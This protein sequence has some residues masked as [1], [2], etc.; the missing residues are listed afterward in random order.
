MRSVWIGLA[1]GVVLSTVVEA[2]LQ[3]PKA[4]VSR[5][6]TPQNERFQFVAATDGAEGM[7]FNPAT[8]ASSRGINVHYNTL[9]DRGKFLEHDFFL[10]NFLFN[11]GY[12]RA[13]DNSLDYHLNEYTVSLGGGIPEVTFGGSVNWLRGNL[14]NGSNGTRYTLGLLVKPHPRFSS[15]VVKS[16]INQPVIGGYKVVGKN[17]I[18]VGVYPLT[19][20]ERLT[21]AADASL[22]N[23]GNV[24]DDLEYRFLAD[25]LVVEGL[26]LYGVYG[27]IPQIDSKQFSI[28]VHVYTP[29]IDFSYDAQFDRDRDYNNGVAGVTFSTERKKSVFNP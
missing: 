1:S 29:N 20:I 14:P 2:Q 24:S 27:K 11:F 21:L 26:R 23:G 15:S 6:V 28:G 25:F 22:P 3:L 19:E 9:I 10:Q 18:G 17:T 7:R 4:E 8:V 13:L 16:N 12:R 5:I